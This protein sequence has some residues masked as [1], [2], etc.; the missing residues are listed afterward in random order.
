MFFIGKNPGEAGDG[1]DGLM[2]CRIT[3][4]AGWVKVWMSF[5]A[6]ML[7][8]AALGVHAQVRD[9]GIPASP[10]SALL[11]CLA[12]GTGSRPG[13]V[14]EAQGLWPQK[15]MQA[16][17][18]EDETDRDGHSGTD[19][20]PVRPASVPTPGKS[21]G[22]GSYRCPETSFQQGWAVNGSRPRPPPDR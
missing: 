21:E 10:A 1:R 20:A 6:L 2:R 15:V 19:L 5:I 9:L 8:L 7:W 13:K 17:A 14:K 4:R 16:Q 22:A 11:V 3:Q 18:A 12:S